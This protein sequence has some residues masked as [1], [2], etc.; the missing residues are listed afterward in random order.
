VDLEAER[1]QLADEIKQQID[2]KVGPVDIVIEPERARRIAD[3]L[4][5][6]VLVTAQATGEDEQVQLQAGLEYEG[7]K[8]AIP[9]IAGGLIG[10]FAAVA[11]IVYY[12]RRKRAATS[13]SSD[14]EQGARTQPASSQ[15]SS[16]QTPSGS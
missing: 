1:Q 14:R 5:D 6:L 2:R 4:V 3:R 12:R 16:P 11:G 9:L 15:Q 8:S 10:G 7:K 13:G